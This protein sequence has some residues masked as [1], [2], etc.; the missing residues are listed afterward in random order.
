[1][2]M[3]AKKEIEAILRGHGYFAH[4]AA[5]D[6]ILERF[7]VKAKAPTCPIP[8][9]DLG[10]LVAD[11]HEAGRP[12]FADQGLALALSLQKRGLKIVKVAE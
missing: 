10:G 2:T 7:D 5:V 1:M 11:A 4:G 6:A 9:H 3:N 12:T 8:F